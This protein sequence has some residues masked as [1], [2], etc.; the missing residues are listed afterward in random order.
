MTRFTP[1]GRPA[2]PGD[3]APVVLFL[4]SDAAGL[5]TGADLNLDGG[6]VDIG[7][8]D[9]VAKEYAHPRA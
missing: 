9:A 4:C 2:E 5:I 7:V 6:L 8:Y 1:L 3:I